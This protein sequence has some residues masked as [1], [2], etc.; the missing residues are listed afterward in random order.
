LNGGKLVEVFCG[1]PPELLVV[2]LAVVVVVVVGVTVGA[3][4]VELGVAEELV[5]AGLEDVVEPEEPPLAEEA[6]EQMALAASK[7]DA[8]SAAQAE[9]TQPWAADWMARYAELEHWQAYSNWPQPT[10]AAAE[11]MQGT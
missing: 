3:E 5:G 6:H 1:R 9:I 10:A 7:T 8:I 11:L 4:L 2:G